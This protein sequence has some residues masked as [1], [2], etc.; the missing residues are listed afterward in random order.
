MNTQEQLRTKLERLQIEMEQLQSELDEYKEEKYLVPPPLCM[1][2]R[3]D[4]ED[5]VCEEMEARAKRAAATETS[6]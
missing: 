3:K 6:K 5:W 2:R 4:Y 1:N